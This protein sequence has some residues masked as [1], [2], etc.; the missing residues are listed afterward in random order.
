MVLQ[1]HAI[2]VASAVSIATAPFMRHLMVRNTDLSAQAS[3]AVASSPSRSNTSPYRRRGSMTP[4]R[5]EGSAK[6]PQIA[7]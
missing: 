3:Q 2:T 4:L 1:M 7:A 5:T 6:M